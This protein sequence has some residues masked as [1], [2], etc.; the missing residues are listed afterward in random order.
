MLY[1][2]FVQ[3]FANREIKVEVVLDWLDCGISH[4]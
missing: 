4:V 2:G 3:R 1:V